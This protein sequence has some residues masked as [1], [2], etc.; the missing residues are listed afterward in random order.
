MNE[1]E[2]CVLQITYLDPRLTLTKVFPQFKNEVV[3][4]ERSM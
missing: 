2:Q 4:G 3:G 1:E